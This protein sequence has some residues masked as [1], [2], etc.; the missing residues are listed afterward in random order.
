[1]SL[2][3]GK[4]GSGRLLNPFPSTHVIKE[5]ATM[6]YN[7]SECEDTMINTGN[8]FQEHMFHLLQD[9][10]LKALQSS[11]YTFCRHLL[12]LS[13]KGF[14]IHLMEITFHWWPKQPQL[15]SLNVSN[16]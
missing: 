10:S 9:N 1:M 4:E 2:H 7:S 16:V 14:L 13:L 5:E 6:A 12:I 8:H 3:H 15:L 11:D